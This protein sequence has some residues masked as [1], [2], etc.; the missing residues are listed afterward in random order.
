MIEK[1]IFTID[2]LMERYSVSRNTIY[3]WTRSGKLPQPTKLPARGH[4]WSK[5]VIELWESKL[6]ASK[7]LINEAAQNAALGA[8]IAVG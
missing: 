5:R 8:R 2:D 4:R 7:T 1:D 6:D 3:R